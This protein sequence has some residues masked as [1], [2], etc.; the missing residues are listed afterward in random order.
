MSRGPEQVA[1]PD[2]TNKNWTDAKKILTDAG[3]VLKYSPVAD[4]F[5]S[6]TTVTKTSPAAGQTV[7]KGSV[8]KVSTA[9]FGSG[10]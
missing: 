4:A 2:V 9:T 7:D 6:L 3:F 5:P 1:V 8:V 10:G